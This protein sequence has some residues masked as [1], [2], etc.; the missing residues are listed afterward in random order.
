MFGIRAGLIAIIKIEKGWITT[1]D[2]LS[3]AIR[4]NKE[5][6]ICIC[7]DL[8]MCPDNCVFTVLNHR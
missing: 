7:T 4:A 2:L 6:T 3:K 1:R 8:I 5:E